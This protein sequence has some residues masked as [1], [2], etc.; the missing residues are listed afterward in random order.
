MHQ[1][2]QLEKFT[3]I[4]AP[5]IHA[6]FHYTTI[7]PGSQRFPA[8]GNH[9][10][11][12]G[13]KAGVVGSF[14]A[15]L[16]SPPPMRGKGKLENLTRTIIR[17]TPAYAGKSLHVVWFFVNVQDHPRLCGEKLVFLSLLI[18]LLGS[19]PPMRGKAHG[20]VCHLR[21]HRI[22][23]AYAGK[24]V[25]LCTISSRS[26]DHPRLCGEKRFHDVLLIF[27]RGSPPPMRGKAQSL[28]GRLYQWR[29]TPAYAGKS[30]PASDKDQLSRDHPRLCG[31]KYGFSSRK[32]LHRGSPPPMRGKVPG[33]KS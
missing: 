26:K 32:R 6:S 23:P 21:H 20:S 10:R 25:D 17:I 18:L 19:P 33:C 5:T 24:R 11:L 4:F 27:R 8:D 7:H 14:I 13:E 15:G 1:N 3:D 12:C 31:E 9:P 28:H 2:F 16:G 30:P 29:I 22:T